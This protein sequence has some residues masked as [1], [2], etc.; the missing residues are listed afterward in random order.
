MVEL[1]EIK[2]ATGQLNYLTP[3][4]FT[5][6]FF[7]A[8]VDIS[9]DAIAISVTGKKLPNVYKSYPKNDFTR[10]MNFF[11]SLLKLSKNMG[12][13]GKIMVATGFEKLSKVQ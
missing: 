12:N 5:Q 11:T 13:L 4:F 2:C 6:F 3:D 10:K 9:R 7:C 1:E 8:F